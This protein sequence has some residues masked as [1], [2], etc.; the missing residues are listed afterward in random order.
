MGA[1]ADARSRPSSPAPA[2][3]G[4]IRPWEF[5]PAWA[6]YVP[7]VPWIVALAA[8]HGWRAIAAANPGMPDGGLVGES[9]FDILATLPPR[10]TVASA[11]IPRGP[12]PVRIH[13]VER[14]CEKAGQ[15][16]PLILK[17]DVG[18]RGAGV[19]R[20]S[21]VEDV[22]AYLR[23][24]DYPVVVQ[25]WHR[26]RSR[27]ALLLAASEATRGRDLLDHRQGVPGD[28]G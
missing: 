1:V 27:P 19:R 18:Q 11:R 14:F 9:K 28:R 25:P 8:R 4:W 26:D 22:A 2:G 24:A 23:D 20:V 3:A 12:V 15:T 5:W 17:P 21:T 16:F 7:L 13:A 6:A 10:W